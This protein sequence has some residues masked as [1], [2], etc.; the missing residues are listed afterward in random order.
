MY[1]CV[2]SIFK[3][4]YSIKHT[5]TCIYLINIYMYIHVLCK[6]K[7]LFWM[8][9][10][11]INQFDSTKYSRCFWVIGE[12]TDDYRWLGIVLDV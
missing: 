12:I 6:H 1:V 8:R 4:I 9:L 5:H 10:I 3:C 11:V 7:L 2:Q